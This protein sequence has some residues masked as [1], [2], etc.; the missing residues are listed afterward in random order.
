[1]NYKEAK[2]WVSGECSTVNTILQDPI[3]T[4]GVRIAQAD[5]AMIQQAYWVLKAHKESLL[6]EPDIP[7]F[8]GT[9]EMLSNLKI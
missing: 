4:W 2:A 8:E 6:D 7:G 5:A 9:T 1:M 3:E